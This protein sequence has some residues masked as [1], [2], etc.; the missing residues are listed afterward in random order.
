MKIKE[1]KLNGCYQI[2]TDLYTD[3]RGVFVKT[4]HHEIFMK[5][6]LQTEYKEEYYS[7]SYEGVLRGL[8]FQIPPYDHDKL[9]YCIYGSVVDVVVD[10]RNGSPTYGKFELFNLNSQNGMSV[11]I[12][13][14][15]AHGFYVTSKEAIMVYN[16]SEVHSPTHDSGIRWDSIGIQWPNN[17]PIMSERDKQFTPFSQFVSPFQ[18]KESE[19]N[20]RK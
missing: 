10:L 1:T 2:T 6:N 11:L 12:P 15:M 8:H 19:T 3:E 13:R 17:N 14:G 7:H 5:L 4:F 18:Y 16:V 9:V 20:E